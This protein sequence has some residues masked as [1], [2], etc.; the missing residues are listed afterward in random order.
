MPA[1]VFP[2]VSDDFVKLN[3][4]YY[5][6]IPDDI[7]KALNDNGV[8][9]QI[10]EKVTQV[11]PELKGVHPRGWPKGSTWDSAEGLYRQADKTVLNCENVR[12][13]GQKVFQKNN[14]PESIFKHETGHAVDK[15]V[16][17][18]FSHTDNFADAWMTDAMNLSEKQK[19]T[20]SYLLQKGN[21]GR[22]ETFAEIFSDLMGNVGYLKAAETF[23]NTT[24]LIK[25][26]LK[27]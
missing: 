27:L 2:G 14:R 7:K 15:A 17:D 24:K 26:T 1:E 9:F 20:H 10:G 23:P 21:A 18:K 4:K 16:L 3:Q 19:R 13:I 11:L 25:K 8:K 22:E 12:P 5:N 6:D